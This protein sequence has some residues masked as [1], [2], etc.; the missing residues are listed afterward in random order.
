MRGVYLLLA[1]LVLFLQLLPLETAPRGWVGPDL[2]LAL[3]F[4]WVA[5]R[6]DLAPVWAV[7]GMLLLSDLLLQRP[8]GLWSA[9]ALIAAEALRARTDDFRDMPFTFEWL[10]VASFLL[11]L[12]LAY[13]LAWSVLVPFDIAYGLLALQMA[14]TILA[15][16]FVVAFSGWLLGVA[17]AAPGQT[18]AQGRKL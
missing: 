14:L 5:R 18:D 6:P 13:M 11:G 17:K 12:Y 3:T 16:P 1:C 7:A 15:Y 10:I 2:L 4:A 8:P 9:L